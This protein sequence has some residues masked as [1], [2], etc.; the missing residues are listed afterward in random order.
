MSK[1]DVTD[2]IRIFIEKYHNDA[3]MVKMPTWNFKIKQI[4]NV[5]LSEISLKEVSTN[6][7]TF[8]ATAEIIKTDGSETIPMREKVNMAGN[9]DVLHYINVGMMEELPEVKSVTITQIRG[10]K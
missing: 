3:N 8:D 2:A 5:N 6:L 7:W 10:I 4:F 1:K 9:A